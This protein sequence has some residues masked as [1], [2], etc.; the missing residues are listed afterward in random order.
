MAKVS[1]VQLDT[2]PSELYF[3]GLKPGDRFTNSRIVRNNLLLTRKH[4]KGITQKSLLPTVSSMWQMLSDEEK[5]A[6]A[7]AGAQCG[8]NGW[9]LFVKDTTARI[10]NEISGLATPSLLHQAFVGNLHVESPANE[11][12]IEQLH[13]Q[14]Y[15]VYRK[16]A[17]TKGQYQNVS[18]IEAFSLPLT[19]SLNYKSDLSVFSSPNFARYIATIWHSYQGVDYLTDFV[20]DLDYSADWQHA[21][22]DVTNVIG[23]VVGYTL[24]LWIKGLRGDLFFDNIKSEHN[25]QNWVRD[26]FCN[27]I[28][29]TFTKAFFQIPKHWVAVNLPDGTDFESVYPAD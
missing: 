26:T 11:I 5:T 20:I 12:Q 21:E 17:G 29:Q 14:N 6:W 22:L 15:Y 7:D 25:G 23:Q 2:V 27:N 8:L 9:R 10:Q 24:Q 18:V 13:P 28:D 1:Y 19:I 3:R 4:R 16:I